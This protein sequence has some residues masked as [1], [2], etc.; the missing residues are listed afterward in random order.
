VGLRARLELWDGVLEQIDA[1]KSAAYSTMRPPRSSSRV[2]LHIPAGS[3]GA[4]GS[5]KR[6]RRAAR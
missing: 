6:A 2:K 5:G 3:E 1:S 4:W